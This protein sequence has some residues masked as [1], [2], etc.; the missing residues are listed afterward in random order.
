MKGAAF[1]SKKYTSDELDK[2]S[3]QELKLMVLSMQGQ[4]DK[5]NENLEVLIEQIRIANQQRFGRHTEKLSS[6]S[7]RPTFFFQ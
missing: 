4:I 2:C 1:M 5:M 3:K 7:R 6:Y